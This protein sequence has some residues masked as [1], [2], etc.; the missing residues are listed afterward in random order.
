MATVIDPQQEGDPTEVKAMA[1]EILEEAYRLYEEKQDYGLLFHESGL[2]V[3]V[4]GFTTLR[5]ADAWAAKR[6][7]AP[8]E[9]QYTTVREV[10]QL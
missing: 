4:R 8:G 6:G 2:W 1:K 5:A 10:G 9:A 3:T 7:L